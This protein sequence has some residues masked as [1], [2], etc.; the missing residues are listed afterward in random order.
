MKVPQ[1]IINLMKRSKYEY[2]FLDDK[3]ASVGYTIRLVKRTEYQKIDTFK[4]EIYKLKKW[5]DKEY[6]KIANA[7]P[8]VCYI[9]SIPQ[10]THY[11]KQYAL[12]TIFDPIMK[13]IEQYI[14]KI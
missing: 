9:L 7:E 2:D 14:P 8:D 3:N 13:S 10:K 5:V 6:K 11:T 12:V 4:N 1:Y